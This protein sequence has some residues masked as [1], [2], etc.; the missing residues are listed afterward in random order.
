[1]SVNFRASHEPHSRPTMLLQNNKYGV[2][3]ICGAFED[4]YFE[5][6]PTIDL[7]LFD[8]PGV[9]D[10]MRDYEMWM[11]N[12]FSHID[13]L[14]DQNAGLIMCSRERK[15]GTFFKGIV[16]TYTA[17]QFGWQPFRMMMWDKMS[18]FHRGHYV[19]QSIPILRRGNMPTDANGPLRYRDIIRM[20]DLSTTQ[21]ATVSELPIELVK[22]LL[23]VFNKPKLVMDPF[24]G[25]G[26]TI[27][28]CLELGIPC[29]TVELDP[30]QANLIASRVQTIIDSMEASK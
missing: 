29:I 27:V 3:V 5:G 25:S 23:A 15:G 8:T 11:E 16:D 10:K 9:D 30:D 24:G 1:M 12:I 26:S 18:D 19:F 13:E 28:A 7:F 21:E 2:S 20:K 17:L 22:L 6:D 14:A 4:L